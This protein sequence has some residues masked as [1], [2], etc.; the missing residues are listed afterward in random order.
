MKKRDVKKTV[1]RSANHFGVVLEHIDSKLDLVAEGQHALGEQ[2]QI[3][4]GKVDE[5]HKE[6]DYKFGVVFDELHMI[7]SE[8]KEKVSRDEFVILEKRVLHLEKK[9]SHSSK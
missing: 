2:I 1:S 9:T 8:L 5:L 7:R 6:M 4:D 3:V